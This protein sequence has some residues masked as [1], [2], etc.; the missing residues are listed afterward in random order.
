LKNEKIRITKTSMDE[1]DRNDRQQEWKQ[2]EK[3]RLIKEYNEL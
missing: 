1:E 2:K 3:E